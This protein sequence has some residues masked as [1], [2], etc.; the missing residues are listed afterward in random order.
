MK[1]VNKWLSPLGLGW[2]EVTL[3]WHSK[4]KD[5]LRWFPTDD[6]TDVV[7]AKTYVYW[8]YGTAA[9][10]INLPAFKGMSRW[11]IEKIVIHELL[12]ILVNEMRVEG[13]EHEER[14]VTTLTKAVLWTR[15]ATHRGE[16]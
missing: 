15:N 14:V 11:K 10:H 6:R 4:P 8:I 3:H 1:A 7:V 13:I 9:L 12:H 5:V 16:L 2:W